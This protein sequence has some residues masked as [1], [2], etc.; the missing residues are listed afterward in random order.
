VTKRFNLNKI[1]NSNEFYVAITVL[2]LCII[3]GMRNSNF[4]TIHTLF[5]LIRAAVVPGIMVFAVKMGII[6]GGI[7]VS[8][9]AIA[10]SSMFLTARYFDSID[11][12]GPMIWPIL[13]SIAIGTV[14]GAFNGVIIALFRLPAFIVTLGTAHLYQGVFVWLIG[15]A[16][17][18]RLPPSMEAMSRAELYRVTGDVHASSIPVTFLFLV[19]IILVVYFILKYTMLGRGIYAIG[20]DMV[21]AERAGFP[22]KGI[23]IFVYTFI[24]F[25]SGLSGILH[26]IQS[27]RSVPTDIVGS[28]L[29]IIAAC[30]LGGTSISGGKGTVLGSI[31]GLALITIARNN[32]VMM[33]IPST[34]QQ[35][36]VGIIIVVGTGISAYQAMKKE[37]KLPRILEKTVPSGGDSVEK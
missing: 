32:L 1:K 13:M 28:E 34:A 30:V 25:A 37:N 18:E 33:G 35:L 19:A 8:F 29:L 7:D 36:V 14:L 21:S 23:T 27:R 16:A 5:N 2:I 24:G 26:A 20:G 12:S 9:P 6:A 22:V 17:V 31:L 10:M 3:I 11:F 4:F 15:S